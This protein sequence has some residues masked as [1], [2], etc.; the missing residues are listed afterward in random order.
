MKCTRRAFLG[1]MAAAGFSAGMEGRGFAATGDGSQS[2]RRYNLSV[3]IDALK[4][5]PELLDIV[6]GAGVTDLW[7][8]CFF[9][10]NFYHPIEEVMEWKGRIE[11]K[12]MAVHNI[13]I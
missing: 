6:G 1:G 13:T 5:D 11:A 7:L 12:G 8:A 9:N 2:V 3:S 10:G 4:A